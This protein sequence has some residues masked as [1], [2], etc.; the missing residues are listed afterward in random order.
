MR[1]RIK[2]SSGFSDHHFIVKKTKTEATQLY[3]FGLNSDGQLGLGHINNQF[4]PAVL[5]F[6]DDKEVEAVHCG[7]RFTLV[8][9]SKALFGFGCSD[10]WQLGF[11]Y[12]SQDL[13]KPLS[14]FRDK[15]ID[16]I[17]CG[18]HHTLIKTSTGLYGF[19]LN[20]YGQL[21]LEHDGS[22]RNPT[23][24]KFFQ[25]KE[26]D[27]ICCGHNHTLVKTFNDI[28]VFGRNSHYQLGNHDANIFHPTSLRFFQGEDIKEICC[29]SNHTLVRTSTGLWGFGDNR[30]GQLGIPGLGGMNIPITYL[31][32][33]RDH[34]IEAICCGHEHTLV[35]TSKGLFG[36]GDD[37]RGQIGHGPI[38]HQWTPVV[39]DF[40][41]DKEIEEI[42]CGGAHTLIK[43]P[44]GIYA[45]GDNQFGQLGLGIR[46][47]QSRPVLLPSSESAKTVILIPRH[48]RKRRLLVMARALCQ[49]SLVSEDYLPLDVFRVL[50]FECR[51]TTKF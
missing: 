4:S 29:G 30:F 43:T 23:P 2:T 32:F 1:P 34:E 47:T 27:E 41:Q 28:Y 35:K 26:I 6:F 12:G 7:G 48:A 49:E 39:L 38:R 36:F 44:A 20:R 46:D 42:S 37:G 13:P 24:L 8:K 3:G 31:V 16:E 33:F 9:T 11:M 15:E 40:F 21:G 18:I 25:D 19:G 17:C 50:L 22:Y 10:S 5:S 14:F 51:M 45:F